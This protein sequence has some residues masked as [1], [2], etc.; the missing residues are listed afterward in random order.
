MPSFHHRKL[1]EHSTLLSGHTPP[2]GTGFKSE[3]LQIWYNNTTTGW[4]DPIPHLHT[5][6]D[7]CFIV[8]RG[9]LR[10]EVEEEQYTIGPG[11]FCCFPAGVYHSIIEVYPPAETLMV[12]APSINDKI[13]QES[14]R[15]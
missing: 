9:S 3:R 13:E 12:R 6:S 4:A 5:E 1:P 15:D 11:E 10:I 14:R 8:L 7:E 2:D